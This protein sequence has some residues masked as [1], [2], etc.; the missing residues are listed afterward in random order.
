[1]NHMKEPMLYQK[2]TKIFTYTKKKVEKLLNQK[3]DTDVNK[4]DVNN[5]IHAMRLQKIKEDLNI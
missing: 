3:F 5:R 2:I 4:F 1:M